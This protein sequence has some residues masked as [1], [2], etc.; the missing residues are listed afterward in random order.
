MHTHKVWDE[1]AIT[2]SRWLS[3]RWEFDTKRCTARHAQRVGSSQMLSSGF[4]L[5]GFQSAEEKHC[6]EF[7]EL[8]WTIIK[9][10]CYCYSF[11]FSVCSFWWFFKAL[12][13]KLFFNL[14]SRGHSLINIIMW[15]PHSGLGMSSCL[16]WEES[17]VGD[18]QA[19]W[20]S[21]VLVFCE[22]VKRKQSVKAELSVYR[23]SPL[24]TSC[25]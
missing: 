2:T 8:E 19:N 25:C 21:P 1:I 17:G 20:P 7:E 23:T 11:I 22:L 9:S 12:T 13:L 6:V 4:F 18:W 3:S 15:I 16:E 5:L 24:F 14:S 10:S